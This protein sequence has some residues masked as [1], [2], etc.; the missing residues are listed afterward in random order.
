MKHLLLGIFL[1]VWLAMLIAWLERH[2]MFCYADTVFYIIT[3]IL[4]L[5]ASFRY[6]LK[7]ISVVSPR[8][9]IWINRI[10]TPPT[11]TPIDAEYLEKAYW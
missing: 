2:Q 5:I 3:A 11:P 8:F 7:V 1:G 4:V 10:L 9:Y 6:I